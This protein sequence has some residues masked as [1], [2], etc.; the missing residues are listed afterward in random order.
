MSGLALLVLAYVSLAVFAAVTLWRTVRLARLPVHLRWELAPVP[1]EKGKS[2]YGGS[3]FEE[4]EWWTKPRSR[5]LVSELVYMFEEIVFLKALWKN[6][7]SLWRFSFPFHFGLY[8]LIV[9]GG[10]ALLGAVLDR[11]GLAVSSWVVFRLMIL[12]L[13]AAGYTL[14]YRGCSRLARVP[15][16][17]SPPSALPNHFSALQSFL[18]SAGLAERPF[19]SEHHR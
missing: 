16:L 4:Y 7:R 9:A 17:G 14:R 1:H 13:A 3:Y 19:R 8:L 15:P 12:V 10:A 11:A 6:N 18:S 5:S 2:H